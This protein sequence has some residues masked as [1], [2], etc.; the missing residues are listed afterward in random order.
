[1]INTT[2]VIVPEHL[3]NIMK[4][5]DNINEI[6]RDDLVQTIGRQS[7]VSIWHKVEKQADHWL[8]EMEGK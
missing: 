4:I 6:V 3:G 7:R 5:F 1:M 8:R 2:I